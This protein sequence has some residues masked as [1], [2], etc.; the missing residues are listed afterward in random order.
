MVREP[1]L[2]TV[3]ITD[4]RPTQITVGMREVKAKRKHWEEIGLKKG[5][6]FL[7]NHMIPVILG[8]KKRNYVIDHH[9]LSLALHEE[10]VKNVAVTV[11]AN[12][13]KL[14]PDEFWN[15]MDNRSWM[16]PF[17]DNGVRRHY[18]DIPKSIIELVDDPFRSLA[19]ELRRSGGYAKDTTPFSEFIWAEFLR[20]RIK[21]KTVENDFDGSLEK[22]LQLAKSLDA[23]YLPGWCG[24]A[25][26][27]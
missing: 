15:V 23:N 4:L 19:G 1:L 2:T 9:H 21:R 10:K 27:D 3:A 5:S 16:H 20:R 25:P 24:P 11:I 17:D 22:A 7:G 8:P 18:K 13:S 26:G 14:E 12:L 6:R